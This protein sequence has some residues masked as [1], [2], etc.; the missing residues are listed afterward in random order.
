LA[1]RAIF[2]FWLNLVAF[3]GLCCG[4]HLAIGLT[5]MRRG[6]FAITLLISLLVVT[7]AFAGPI[8][9]HTADQAVSAASDG[10][11]PITGHT[12]DQPVSA[13]SEP[14]SGGDE[15]S[16]VAT[17][18]T[19]GSLFDPIGI[20]LLRSSGPYYLE[21]GQHGKLR[22][23]GGEGGGAYSTG[24]A[25]PVGNLAPELSFGAADPLPFTPTVAM[26]EPA[27]LLLL[28]PAA[29]LAWRRRAGL[30]R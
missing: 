13:A 24:G 2:R 30:R 17:S 12:A 8:T 7:P 27:T 19:A 25:L 14:A 23:G 29:L 6:L 26:P 15:S 5:I 1:G 4:L 3:Y 10:A 16:P 21:L 22:G 9:G 20:P 11:A 18:F 28:A